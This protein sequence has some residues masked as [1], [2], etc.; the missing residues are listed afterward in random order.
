MNGLGGLNKS[1]NGSC[2]GWCSCTCQWWRRLPTSRRRPK[3]SSRWSA[4]PGA[5]CRRWISS[6]SRIC[7]ARPFDEHGPGHHVPHGRAGGRSLQA[8]CIE[9]RS[10]LFLH[11]GA[12]PGRQSHNTGLVIDDRGAVKLYY[13]K[14][15]P[16]VPVEPWEPGD[17]GIPVIDG[18][19]GA[20]LAL[21]ICHDGMFPKW[22]AS[23]PTRAPKSCCALRIYRTDPPVLGIHQSGQCLLQPDGDRNVCMCGS[24][25]TF[26]S[27]ARPWSSISTG[28]SSRMARPA[29]R[30]RSSRRKFARPRARGAPALVGRK[31]HLSVRPS[32]LYGRCGRRAGLP[33]H[34]HARP[35]QGRYRLPWE[36]DVVHVDGTSCGFAK[37]TRLYGETCQSAE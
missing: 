35:D 14:L 17:L 29:G 32:R 5:T 16:W 21:I 11:H 30:T 31:Q 3:R 26:D 2:W 6:S 13:R 23:A 28:R 27:M 7:A 33:L 36:D 20:K 15:H 37:P 24:D 18:P 22:R 25:G 4:R 9:H 19:R 10:G 8:A 34:L 12:Q 1:P